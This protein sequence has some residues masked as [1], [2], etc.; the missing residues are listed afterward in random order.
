M[1]SQVQAQPSLDAVVTSTNDQLAA[2]ELEL[3]NAWVGVLKIVNQPIR[4]FARTPDLKVSTFSPGWFH[5]GAGRPNFHTVDV[6]QT[7]EPL[8][9][10]HPYVTSDLNPGIVF[11]AQDLEFNATT[12][13]FYT[14]RT[15]PK[16][17][18]SEPEM[19]EINR[20]YRIIGRCQREISWIRNS[21][22]SLEMEEIE[23]EAEVE[24]GNLVDQIRNIPPRTRM[25]YGSLAIGAIVLLA[26]LLRL[27]KS[28][29]R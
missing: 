16:R 18:L 7:Q 23:V 11:L 10:S 13:Y 15:L 19:V 9:A 12:K 21:A 3:T 28:S 27:V 24:P 25:L 29:P 22:E 6:R 14:N 20:L 8:K 4:A 26:L 17:R 2:L 5:E 1:A